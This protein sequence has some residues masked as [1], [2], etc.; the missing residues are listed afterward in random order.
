MRHFLLVPGLLLLHSLSFGQ[1]SLT[2][3]GTPYV[4]NFNTLT[5]SATNGGTVTWTD[6]T[7]LSGWYAAHSGT[8]NLMTQLAA[9]ARSN[10]GRLYAVVSGTDKSLGSRASGSTNTI[11]Y[12]VRLQNNTGTT[13]TSL[14]ISYYGEQ[15]SIAENASNVNTISV[16]YKIAASITSTTGGTWTSAPALN[17]TQIWGSANSSGLGGSACTG[18]SNQC[19]SL[20]G[21][22]AA[23]RILITAC[24]DIVIPAGQEFF[25][26]WSD[27][28]D[29][30]NDHHMQIDDLS[31]TP[32]TDNCS[33]V[34]PVT[35]GNIE[36]ETKGNDA[37][38]NWS[39]YS[40]T[41][42]DYFSLELFN[43][44]H[45]AFENIKQVKS[46][47]DHTDTYNY[48]LTIQNLE[49]KEYFFR[50]RQTDMDGR[51]SYSPVQLFKI[52]SDENFV[53]Y[54][55]GTLTSSQEFD[56]GTIV[57]IIDMNGNILF[58]TETNE[59]TKSIPVPAL[60]PGIVLVRQQHNGQ[61]RTNKL[62]VNQN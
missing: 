28:D 9:S 47:G 29:S 58:Q 55:E 51:N 48:Q 46:I 56:P 43:L 61:T 12:G 19:L 50:I 18:N 41:S 23:N 16:D 21:N 17:F 3:I 13:I 8:F 45:H 24:L 34:L 44:D 32:F 35:W 40:E 20:D 14:N 22:A 4:E 57:S 1:I 33:T 54:S 10:T 11:T 30:A 7:N 37:T 62:L 59:L 31:I 36:S 6:N 15:W 42:N 5:C 60:D 49:A 27:P 25:L 2:A 53:S 39:V 38:I 52:V 26:R